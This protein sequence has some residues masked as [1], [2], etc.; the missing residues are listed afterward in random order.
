MEFQ[1]KTILSKTNS[2]FLLRIKKSERKKSFECMRLNVYRQ[3]FIKEEERCRWRTT[4]GRN[5]FQQNCTESLTGFSSVRLHWIVVSFSIH[6]TIHIRP[7]IESWCPGDLRGKTVLNSTKGWRKSPRGFKI[8]TGRTVASWRT[9]SLWNER[10]C[11]SPWGRRTPC[12][13]HRSGLPWASRPPRK[14]LR[15]M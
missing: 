1:K 10:W 5:G 6:T 15:I 3:S 8:W 2:I 14:R 4:N 7:S 11:K 9:K 13:C 12:P